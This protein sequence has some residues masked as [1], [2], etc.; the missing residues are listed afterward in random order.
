M[1]GSQL[2]TAHN[3]DVDELVA[4]MISD[5]I[6]WRS[7][8]NI[9]SNGNKCSLIYK[10]IRCI[11]VSDPNAYEPRVLSIGPYHHGAPSLLPMEKEKWL[12]L[13]YVLK[14]SCNKSLHDYLAV[15]AALETEARICYSENS[16]MSSRAYVEMLLLDSCFILVCLNGIGGVKVRTD[17]DEGNS[18][19]QGVMIEVVVGQNEA[20]MLNKKGKETMV[21]EIPGPA[22]SRTNECSAFQTEKYQVHGNEGNKQMNNMDS[23]NVQTQENVD[24]GEQWYN[25]SA[26]YDLLLLEN[27]IPFFIVTRI[28][29]LLV[30]GDKTENR[31]LSDNLSKFIEGVLLHFP[32]AI[33]DTNRPKDFDHLLHLCYMYFKPS[34][35]PQHKHQAMKKRACCIQKLLLWG[36]KCFGMNVNSMENKENPQSHVHS[37]DMHSISEIQRWR[38]AE[39]YHDAGVEF[40]DMEFDENKPHSL[41]DIEFRDGVLHI[42]CLPIDDKFGT[43]FRNLVVFEQS[44]PELGN[45]MASYVYFLSQLISVPDDVALLARK[46]V[47]VH[48]LDCDEEVSTLFTKLFDYVLFDSSGEHY[49]RSL[50][51]TMEAHYQSR[52]N[53]GFYW[54]LIGEGKLPT[55]QLCMHS[56]SGVLQVELIAKV[57]PAMLAA[58]AIVPDEGLGTLVTD[59]ARDRVLRSMLFQDPATKAVIPT[60]KK[61]RASSLRAAIFMHQHF[62]LAAARHV[63]E[64]LIGEWNVI[65]SNTN[66]KTC[67]IDLSYTHSEHSLFRSFL[68]G[69]N[70]T[71]VMAEDSASNVDSVEIEEIANSMARDLGNAQLPADNFDER[72]NS[73]Q[74][75]RVHRLVRQIDSFAYEPSVL[76]IGPYHYKNASLQFMERL[77]WRS[78]DY[79]L[80]LNCNKNMRDYLLAIGDIENQARAYYP[81]EMKLDSKD[82]RRML[83]LDGCFILV[84]LDGTHGVPRITK[85][86]PEF[87]LTPDGTILGRGSASH[88]ANTNSFLGN[89]ADLKQDTVLDIELA[90][91]D[92][93]QR[94]S[95]NDDSTSCRQLSVVQWYDIF[96]LL[97]L[98]L[99][100]NQIPFLVVRKIYEVLVGSG[101]GNIVAQHVGNYVEENLLYLTKAF[102]QYD[103]P[104][105]FYHLLH[106]CHMQFRPSMR[107]EETN[108]MMPQFG[109]YFLGIFC[110]LFNFCLRTEQYQRNSSQDKQFNFL[111]AGQLIRWHRATQYH[112]AG[113]IF[114]RREFV[115]QNTYS[116]LDITFHD[117]V[118]EIPCLTVDDRTGSLLRNMIAFEQTCPQFGNF[119]TA[120]VMFMSQLIS[121]PDD[122]TLLSQRGIIVHF[123]H[124]DNVVSSLFTGLTKGVVFDFMGN[125]Y[126]RSICWRMEVYY[127]SRINRWI[128]WLRH[129]HLSNPW[130]GLALIA[131]LL[132]LFCTIAQTVL[133]VLA[134]GGPP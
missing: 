58:E 52:L 90:T 119:V 19:D 107:M 10:V 34:R 101:M 65:V 13:D 46:G 71:G 133:T 38:R 77:K 51:Q 32:L 127:Q 62:H 3:G 100:E 16:I 106:L 44:C 35:I 80:K 122:V 48:Q 59:G 67:E 4:S 22:S 99:L 81:D 27:Q 30:H 1:S 121:R 129:N 2:Y 125:F 43:L 29:E 68:C 82:F 39:Q 9:N 126:L 23:Y 88:H 104:T 41:L 134:Y 118:L 76:S 91:V 78:L 70:Y 42:P 20:N 63:E 110:N 45:D 8:G 17:I 12:C 83:M 18:Q 79:V 66:D 40:K 131:G 123:L 113:I 57:N 14:L 115:G 85:A 56:Y 102:G 5:L 11:R 108:H 31:L 21:D 47:I 50:C 6:Y 128:A 130:L 37:E 103:R 53:S 7:L 105:D 55:F 95:E 116:M 87:S 109:E 15:I 72:G 98:F 89:G 54:N 117:G 94:S 96:S 86:E 73:F 112:E 74:I 61:T 111:Q 24:H 64:D 36:Y 97:D 60:S 33:Q 114:K 26:V 49:L 84:Y 69:Y 93:G 124:S 75:L 92:V 25:S 132:V 120:Y 28:Y